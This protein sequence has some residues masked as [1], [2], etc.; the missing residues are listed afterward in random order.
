MRIAVFTKNL[1]N[2][3]YEGAR[4]G[5]DRA[6]ARH[7]ATTMHYVPNKPDSPEEQL[8]LIDLAL[9][10]SPNAFVLVPAHPTAVNPGIER[11]NASGIPLV[12]FVNR[13]TAGHSVSFVSADDYQ[14][15]LKVAHRMYAHLGGRGRIVLVEGPGDSVTS[16][17]RVKA[18]R[19]AALDYPGI[20]IVASCHGAFLREPA[21]LELT[22]LLASTPAIDAVLA[23]NDSM[24]LGA[25]DA[26]EAAGRHAAVAGI[27]AVPEAIEAIRQGRLLATADFNAMDMA[28]VATECAI[29]HIQGEPV[30]NEIL[31]PAQLVDADNYARWD[32]PFA[33]RECPEWGDVT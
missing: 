31:L 21:R 3:A 12:T 22:R 2:P 11:I 5:A 27:N 29:R 26:L 1:L 25:I 9:A 28:D 18:F 32:K 30:P 20:D 15:A 6:A 24:A 4:L 14:L 23:A 10:E 17:P 33:E 7:G 13:L 8:A 19:D 16:V